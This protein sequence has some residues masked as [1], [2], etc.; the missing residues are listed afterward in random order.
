MKSNQT[1]NAKIIIAKVPILG[2]VILFCFRALTPLK[3]L[4]NQ[5]I[6]S[7]KWLFTSRET[8]NFT[9]YLTEENKHYL[10]ALIADILDLEHSVILGY[11]HELEADEELKQHIINSTKNN[12][13]SIIADKEVR[14]GR[15]IGWYAF[16]R[17]LKPKVIVETGVDKGLG[18]CVLTAA[19][20]RNK[21][22]GYEGKY[23]GTDINPQAGYL[24]N[25]KYAD[26]GTILYGDSLESLKNFDGMIDLFIN[27]S[28]HSA[29]YEAREYEAI[30]DKLSENSLI[31]GDNSDTTDKLLLF[32]LAK[33]RRFIF[34]QEKPLKSWYPGAGIGI[35]FIRNS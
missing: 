20:I 14:F 25:G 19:L 18:S 2:N 34:F 16:A 29:D 32:S 4:V 1:I 30:E 9:Y 12:Q 13:R 6:Y 10:A 5:F 15:R 3:Y 7:L 27:D 28:D 33:N 24:L 11:I 17:A 22:E 21:Q 23:F 35:S 8:T 26:F 31:L